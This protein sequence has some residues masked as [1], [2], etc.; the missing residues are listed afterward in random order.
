MAKKKTYVGTTVNRVIEDDKLPDSIRTGLT[1]ALFQEGEVIDYVLDELVESIGL[2]VNRMYEYARSGKY[3]WGLPSGQ[4]TTGEEGRAEVQAVLDAIEGR[5]VLL[6]YAHYGPPNSLHIGWMKLIELHG[7]NPATNQL[8]VL[9]ASK[10][11]PVYLDDMLVVIPG[12]QANTIEPRSLEQWGMAAKAGYTP[13]RS[14]STADTRKLVQPSPVQ[15]ESGGTTEYLRVKYVWKTSAGLQRASLTIPVTGYDDETDYFHAKYL[16]DGVTKYWMYRQGTGTYSTLDQLFDRPPLSNGSFFPFVYFRFDKDSE[17]DDKTLPSYKTAVEITKILGMD[18]DQVADA[19]NQNPDIDDVEH[20]IMMM[21]VPANTEHPLE[22]RYL[23]DFFSTLYEANAEQFYSADQK[24]ISQKELENQLG[25]RTARIVIQDSRFKMQLENDAIFKRRVYGT[26]GAVGSY[27][28]GFEEDSKPITVVDTVTGAPTQILSPGN[29]H[30]FRKQVSPGLYDEIQVVELQTRFWVTGKYSTIGDEEEKILLI[31]LDKA[32]TDSYSLPQR[33]QLYSRALHIVFNSLVVVKVKWYQTGIFKVVMVIVAVV[34]SFYTG[35]TAAGIYSALAAG[36]YQAAAILIL[37]MLVEYVV[38]S[39][40]FKLFVKTVGAKLAFAVA[41]AAAVAG[42]AGALNAGG[43]SGAPWARD[44]LAISSGLSRAVSSQIQLDMRELAGDFEDFE[45]YKAEQLKVLESGQDLLEGNTW[46]S[47]FTIF[48][49]K[50]QDFYNR[51]VHS[52]NIG[53]VGI[54]AVSA[55]VDSKL[56]L[57]K[58]SDTLGG[59]YVG[60]L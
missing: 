55:F 53:V 27:D 4:F 42:A 45:K 11:T 6:D 40:A 54:D 36:A 39:L 22:R 35:G 13:E 16:V 24:K 15:V 48:G 49:E 60:K 26:I 23:F 38:F 5:S 57:P 10:G 3:T 37:T 25:Y 9:T 19:I 59:Q 56:A 31:P 12:S 18:Y 46:L 8:G 29:Y 28:S 14:T 51:T 44:L 17:N 21:A 2:K 50:P 34:I 1:K 47:P 30:Y 7:Y 43:L 41:I 58:L 32:V 52:G 20:A 33:E